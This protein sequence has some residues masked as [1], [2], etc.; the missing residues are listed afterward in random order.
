M[1]RRD[2]LN[3]FKISVNKDIKFF[4]MYFVGESNTIFLKD[5]IDQ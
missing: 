5:L 2:E 1:G 4:I 3:T